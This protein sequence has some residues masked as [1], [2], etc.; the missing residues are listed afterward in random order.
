MLLRGW[1]GLCRSLP[2]NRALHRHQEAP[3]GSAAVQARHPPGAGQPARRCRPWSARG[4]TRSAERRRRRVPFLGGGATPLTVTESPSLS[5]KHCSR[6]HV[7][8]CRRL[9]W[10]SEYPLH[11]RTSVSSGDP[12]VPDPARLWPQPGDAADDQGVQTGP[13]DRA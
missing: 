12:A 8:A 4:G 5:C 13:N 1:A 3:A 6:R 11:S 10:A 9:D 7:P 2:P